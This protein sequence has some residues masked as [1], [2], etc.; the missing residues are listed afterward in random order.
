[1]GIPSFY[2]WLLDRYPRTV[3]DAIEE[4]PPDA[5]KPNP[6]GKEFDNLYLDMNGIVHPCFHPEGLPPPKSYDD[7]FAAV[8]S[9]IDRVFSIVRP[10]KLLF[11]AIDGV[12]PRAKMNQQRSR[13]F[14]AAKDAAAEAAS[15]E[16]T[17][18]SE[19]EKAAYLEQ[20]KK[21]D[22]NVITPGTEFMALLSLALCYYIH[23][24]MNKDPGW[25]GVK[26]I[27]SDANVP[28]EGEHKIMSYIRL[29]RNLPGYD[30][31]TR[32][33][34]YGLDAD[35][36]MLALATHELHFFIL[37]EDVRGA[38]SNDKHQQEN[39]KKS[40]EMEVEGENLEGFISRQKFQF[41][42]ILIL[43]EYLQLD[44]T[45]RAKKKSS[46]KKSI[47]TKKGKKKLKLER[48][49]DDFVFMCL[50]V[51]NDFLP[52]I[53]SLEISEGAIDL[54][55]MV[56]KKEFRKMGGYL[57]DSFKV[58]LKR[59]EH[60]VQVLASHECAIFRRRR[61][62]QKERGL[63]YRR[64]SNKKNTRSS[65]N[66]I[67][68]N[69]RNSSSV[70]TQT[71]INLSSVGTNAVVDE[72]KLGETKGWK[73]RFYAEKFEVEI[74]DV[75]KIR[76]HAVSKY[77][78]GICWVMHYYYEGVCSWQWFYPYHYAPFA[79][80][81]SGVDQLKIEFTLGKPFKPFDQLL[82]VL[83]AASAHALPLFY[84]KLMTDMSSPLSD[85]YP[86]DFELDMNGKHFSWQAVCK[87]PF[88]DESRLLSEISKVEHTLTDEERCRNSFSLDVLFVHASHPLTVKILAFCQRKAV[89]PKFAGTKVKRKINPKFSDG[90]N[91]YM[92]ISDKPVQPVEILSPIEDME[93]ISNNEVLSVFFKCP[94]FHSHITSISKGV[95]VP[96]MSVRK[97]DILPPPVLW[98]KKS[99]VLGRI[100][101]ERSIPKSIS[102]HLLAK[103]A[104]KL[105]SKCYPPRKKW[106][107]ME[108]GDNIG[109]DGFISRLNLI[110]TVPQG[111]AGFYKN[112][113][114]CD[115][116]APDEQ[117]GETG[118]NGL[119]CGR[120]PITNHVNC[121]TL[122]RSLKP[123]RSKA[124]RAM[125]L[126][127]S[128]FELAA[129]AEKNRVN[130]EVPY[131][132]VGETGT[133]RVVC[134]QNLEPT[135]FE[136]V[137]ATDKNCVDG[138]PDNQVGANEANGLVYASGVPDNCVDV[139]SKKKKRKQ[140]KAGGAQN[141]GPTSCEVEMG[142]EKNYVNHEVP[143]THVGE[144]GT[145]RVVCAQNLEPTIFELAAAADKNCVDGVP[146]NH[147]GANE[148]NGLVCASGVLDNCVDVKSKKKK[149]KRSKAGG[150]QNLGPTSC[151]VEMEAEKNCVNHEVPDTHVG[152][153]GTNRVVCAQN[154]EPTIFELAAAADKNCVDGVPDNQEREAEKNCVNHEVPD[155]HVGET[156]TNRV[157]C[158]Q[159]LEPTIFDLAAAADK[160]C[161]DG[162][163]DN[164]VGVNGENGLICASGVPDNCVDVEPKK[165]KRKRSKAGGAQNLGPTSCEVGMGAEK[166]CVNGVPD[167]QVG[168][169]E[170]NGL[171]CASGVLDNCVDVKQSKAG[172]AQNLG[173]TSC[174]V[175][176]GAE[177]N[178]VNHEVPDTHVSET[179]TNSVVCA[180]N[181]EPTNFEVGTAADKN[182][183]DNRDPD[184]HVGETGAN[185]LVH[186][187]GVPDKNCVNVKS[188]KRK[189]KGSKVR[190]A[191]NLELTICEAGTGANLNCV[192]NRVQ[193]KHVGDSVSNGLI[194]P[195][196]V[197]DKNCVDGKSKKK[198][199][200]RCTVG[201]A[202]N[203]EPAI[204]ELETGA[205]EIFV[206]NG[207]QDH[208]VG[209]TGAK[210]L[211]YS[212][213]VQN[214]NVG[215]NGANVLAFG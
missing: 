96:R 66:L 75:E 56:Y 55:M 46:K 172:G 112:C 53:P 162:V 67:S 206:D 127:P 44:M 138:V 85:F 142:A 81:F 57:T 196:G 175:G 147:V 82:S 121:E 157:V 54:L 41:L 30:V 24:R 123:K 13:R 204:C 188:K 165:K 19:E 76:R 88:I 39:M 21:M 137:A 190:G 128:I 214:N 70:E 31:N 18:E 215:E 23:L 40:K 104:R 103:L 117:V 60:F 102:G 10:R 15:R 62:M 143:D 209:E 84:R 198:R 182:C 166:N 16:K 89:H 115:I 183:V 47:F 17:F 191:Q 52:H 163:P 86:T 108:L 4:E 181:L 61:Q 1:M 99:A 105:L 90:M 159:N 140:S 152:E 124:I 119:E 145:N 207:L 154:L 29:Q 141:L 197:L 27:L 153:T 167:S 79:S 91:G 74:K 114:Y 151:E 77:I 80:D 195:S 174:E 43:R 122:I 113:I 42:N 34:L 192:D 150:A 109:V 111:G 35:L 37:R 213:G 11:L 107:S 176:M 208:H 87:L 49:I 92:Y 184:K 33:C 180:Q 177:K 133:N 158:T 131:T 22:S 97:K 48:L 189:P 72:I 12:A 8:F 179:G 132:H 6:N 83:P 126:E 32:H 51:G 161:V 193:D 129:E 38:R 169:N 149:R 116:G 2:R 170:A 178:C 139:K 146:D 3:V 164:Q 25:R 211:E 58:N 78:E 171:V 130:H 186:A 93:I 73:E 50:F 7:I 71:P 45:I 63:R 95:K 20:C 173:P 134:A 36:I 100:H 94:P 9:Y 155:T 120:V 136:L 194:C 199:Q 69:H 26:V 212:D 5:T 118:A 168:A 185:G 160:N 28:G 135:I 200:K 65:S 68:Q 148:A 64:F 59:V 202:E 110:D 14:R 101:S 106:G 156:G 187:S 203:L 205:N 125:D 144:T 201:G 98:H 210:A